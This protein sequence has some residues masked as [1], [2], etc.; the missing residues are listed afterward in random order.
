MI[1][2]KLIISILAISNLSAENKRLSFEDVQGKSPFNYSSI[3]FLNWV[4]NE[5]TYISRHNGKLI[6]VDIFSSDTSL[7]LSNDD[8]YANGNIIV[9][10]GVSKKPEWDK[11]FVPSTFLFDKSGEKILFISKK[12]KIWRRSF[13]ASYFVMDL[14]TKQIYS[15]SEN[16]KKLR[17]GKFSPDGKKVAYVREDNNIYVYDLKK[18]REKQIT[19]NGSE[20][21]LN[22]LHGWVYEEEFGSF[23]AYRWS[24][25]SRFIAYWEEDRSNVP[26]FKLF[27]ELELYPTTQKIFYPKAGEK[28]PIK[29]IFVVDV[30][31]R[32]RKKMNIGDNKDTYYPWL[33]WISNENIIVMRM[34]RLQNFWEFLNISRF[35]GKYHSGLSES[36]PNGWVELHRN[37]HFL[38]DG[39]IIWISE[40]SGWHHIYIHDLKGNL[41]RQLTSGEWEVKNISHIDEKN[42]KY[43]LFQT[44]NQF[45]KIDSIQSILMVAA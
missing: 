41:I 29:N 42:K 21:I 25:D 9:K 1:Y 30:K 3:N 27:D 19:F 10:K 32:N 20:K 18:Y 12:E 36:D 15:I 22:G 43:I 39:N 28:N 16:N 38:N 35:N 45:L 31:N 33:K 40:R 26:V 5:N 34:N 6:K 24:P 8:F 2:I 44:K 37:Y 23:D 14:K 11:K 7:F 13:Y 17:N 4:P